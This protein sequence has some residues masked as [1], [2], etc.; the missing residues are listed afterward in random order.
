MLAIMIA[1]GKNFKIDE[2]NYIIYCKRNGFFNNF[3]KIFTYLGSYYVLVSACFV[4]FVLLFF[5]KKN[6]KLA[7]LTALFFALALLINLAAK[8]I[9][10]R[11][12]PEDLMLVEE[13]SYAFPSGHAMMSC[14]IFSVFAY[15]ICKIIK[16]RPLKVCLIVLFVAI[17]LLI[18]FSRIYLG[19]HYVTDVIAGWLL[20]GALLLIFVVFAN[21][22][23]VIRG[24]KNEKEI[25]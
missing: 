10:Q 25:N 20:A 17:I 6:K 4:C 8:N 12:R 23:I 18:G 13:F 11:S 5:I 19:V 22:I 15:F 7:L 24:D 14:L 21:S 9:I 2:F 3:F 16:N 1:N